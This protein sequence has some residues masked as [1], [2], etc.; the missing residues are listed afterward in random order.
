MS[1]RRAIRVLLVEDNAADGQAFRQYL[2]ERPAGEFKVHQAESLQAALQWLENDSCDVILLDLGLP[3]SQGLQ[4]LIRI[5]ACAAN[6]P[7]LALSETNDEEIESRALQKGAQ[8]YLVKGQ[9]QAPLLHKAIRYA[10]ERHSLERAMMHSEKLQALGTLAG[11]IAHDFN[12]ILVVVSGNAKLALEQLPPG[13]PAYCNVLEIAKAGSRGAALTRKILSFSRDQNSVRQPT[14][15]AAVVEE[16]LSLIRASLPPQIEVRQNFPPELPPILADPSQVHQILVNLVTNAADAIGEGRAQVEI[17]AVTVQLNGNGAGL[18]AKLPPGRYV[19]LSVKDTGPGMDK[20]TLARVFE[21]FFTTK[22]QG[23]G[24]GM[25]LAV[26]HGIMKNH[27]GEVTAYSEVGKGSVFSLYF[28]AAE[29]APAEP[30]AA[31]PSPPGQGQHILY[32]DD[33]EPLVLLV[34]RT[35]Q[36]L[37]YRVS[38]FTNPLHALQA[39]REQPC[40]FHAIVTD[41]SMPQMSGTDFT[42]EALQ[43]CPKLPVILTTGYI[44]P[45]DHELARQAGAREVI[46]KPD[47]VEEMGNALH[48]VL[49]GPGEIQA[50]LHPNG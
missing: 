26:V 30:P 13:H 50:S 9:T 24:T 42:H 36:R 14:R 39:L 7:V 31:A 28:P 34:T 38:G 29:E 1:E 8:D 40:G 10:L 6:T 46:L 4:T 22:T 20:H 35:L 18:S 44:R 2:E 3:D 47:T 11:G 16:V 37:G 43:I 19:K 25:G 5:K 49:S 15:L 21:P 48:R 45:Q 23:R 12:N 33:E 17:S 41:L 32:V 27:L